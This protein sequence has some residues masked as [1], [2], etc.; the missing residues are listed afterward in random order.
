MSFILN[1]EKTRAIILGMPPL[2]RSNLSKLVSSLGVKEVVTVSEHKIALERLE[3]ETFNWIIMDTNWRD[4]INAFNIMK[5]I[6]Q[7]P[8]L[9]HSRVSLMVTEEDTPYLSYAFELGLMSWHPLGVT[10]EECQKEFYYLANTAKR[11]NGDS[12]L[13]SA[14]YLAKHLKISKYFKDLNNFYSKLIYHYP[15]NTEVL[16]GYGES[17]LLRLKADQGK[18]FLQQAVHCSPFGSNKARELLDSN[19]TYEDSLEKS[20]V[21]PRKAFKFSK[22]LIISDRDDVANN[23][24]QTLEDL[25]IESD[26]TPSKIW[27]DQYKKKSHDIIFVDW[28]LRR[29]TAP[30]IL[31]ETLAP[32]HPEICVIA[33]VENPGDLTTSDF[34]AFGFSAKVSTITESDISKALTRSEH[35]AMRGHSLFARIKT[36]A[37]KGK[38]KDAQIIK[39]DYFKKAPI[40][41]AD[42]FLMEAFLANQ[43][44]E[45]LRMSEFCYKA[46]ELPCAKEEALALLGKALSATKQFE[47]AVMAYQQAARTNLRDLGKILSRSISSA[48]KSHQQALDQYPHY[49]F[50]I[51]IDNGFAT[52]LSHRKQ[53]HRAIDKFFECLITIPKEMVELRSIVAYSTAL[54]FCRENYLPEAMACLS[55]ATLSQKKERKMRALTL[56]KKVTKLME[57]NLDYPPPDI[58][59]EGIDKD[60]LRI[61]VA[62]A[63]SKDETDD[64]LRFLFKAEQGVDRLAFLTKNKLDFKKRKTIKRESPFDS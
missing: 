42:R 53:F 29:Q 36:A 37:L 16:T 8:D 30:H 27:K 47:K 54:C 60:N 1:P 56:Q 22:A 5:L 3:I 20:T 17:F 41:D 19:T 62:Q 21:S 33:Y 26:V 40:S 39:S 44:N 50:L 59:D 12:R 4:G 48:D 24:S 9:C 25:D 31:D 32:T 46:L 49:Q 7:T 28:D 13:I 55:E 34:E 18:R 52:S 6:A 2:Y 23:L 38:L 35:R 10:T 58:R 11:Y 14:E 43:T 61:V 63:N 57:D 45:Y 64:G 15:D 51:G